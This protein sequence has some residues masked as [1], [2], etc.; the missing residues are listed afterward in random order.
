MN[1]GLMDASLND[2]IL[3][4]EVLLTPDI[5]EHLRHA[6]TTS[7]PE[8]TVQVESSSVIKDDMDNKTPLFA[9]SV[10]NLIEHSSP[11]DEKEAR[12]A[13]MQSM[14]KMKLPTPD[15]NSTDSHPSKRSITRKTTGEML[16]AAASQLRKERN[17]ISTEV[18]SRLGTPNS[19]A[20]TRHSEVDGNKPS[21]AGAMEAV[22]ESFLVV[23]SLPVQVLHAFFCRLPFFFL[24]FFKA[25]RI[26]TKSSNGTIQVHKEA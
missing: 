25:I 16:V 8:A 2:R 4:Q 11:G 7:N 19:G 6:K 15:G 9:N 21:A 26:S 24:F 1:D 5:Q 17:K 20:K 23:L 13:L 10:K 22:G 14:M 3:F 18:P 12:Y